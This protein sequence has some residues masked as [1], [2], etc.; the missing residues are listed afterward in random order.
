[1]NYDLPDKLSKSFEEEKPKLDE[2]DGV[3]IYGGGIRGLWN[4]WTTWKFNQEEAKQ[5]SPGKDRFSMTIKRKK[6]NRLIIS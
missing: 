6:K 4:L 5:M 2:I 3:T 1:M